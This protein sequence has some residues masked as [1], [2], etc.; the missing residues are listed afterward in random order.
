MAEEHKKILPTLEDEYS[1]M[2]EFRQVKVDAGKKAQWDKKQ[3]SA[4][5]QNIDTRLMDQSPKAEK[6]DE[7]GGQDADNVN[8]PVSNLYQSIRQNRLGME[9]SAADEDDSMAEPDSQTYSEVL[10]E[11]KNESRMKRKEAEEMSN[12]QKMTDQKEAG[13]DDTFSKMTAGVMKWSWVACGT[14]AGIP[15]GLTY[16]NIH[17]FAR[18]MGSSAFCKFGTEWYFGAP[19]VMKKSMEGWTKN[20]GMLEILVLLCLDTLI[21]F[22]IVGFL[23]LIS[24]IVTWMQADWADKIGWAL[25][26]IWDLGWSGIKE[27]V[28]L[29]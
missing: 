5:R 26:G 25:K 20:L 9:G 17:G 28:G 16:L 29:F 23:G 13:S 27:L 12:D 24:M 10:Q 8:D 6:K 14:V 7:E 15:I 21:I 19:K 22:M 11:Q 18:L 4:V 2:R 1:A 3:Q